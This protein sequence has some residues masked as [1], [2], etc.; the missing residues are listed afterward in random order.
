VGTR[1][2]GKGEEDQMKE[3]WANNMVP[4][5][6]R[7]ERLITAA[8]DKLAPEASKEELEKFISEVSNPEDVQAYLDKWADEEADID[9][10]LGE[11]DEEED[12]VVVVVTD[13]EDD[14][15]DDD[16]DMADFVVRDNEDEDEDED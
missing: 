11:E 9:E 3:I 14:D 15:D 6:E 10:G 7:W 4:V 13:D 8:G 16:D 1:A 2:G 5:I 12:D